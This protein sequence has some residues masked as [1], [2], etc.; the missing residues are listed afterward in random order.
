MLTLLFLSTRNLRIANFVLDAFGKKIENVDRFDEIMSSLKSKNNWSF[1]ETL[2]LN[3]IFPIILK[4]YTMN[5]TLLHFSCVL[6][7]Q[8]LICTSQKIIE[9]IY[10]LF[11]R[12]NEDVICFKKKLLEYSYFAFYYRVPIYLNEK[13]NQTTL[14]IENCQFIQE[15]SKKE[16]LEC[17][18]VFYFKILVEKRKEKIFLKHLFFNFNYLLTFS[19]LSL[20]NSM[21]IFQNPM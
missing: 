19:W 5:T 1:N 9:I 11:V 20:A 7:Y 17:W 10:K 13:S 16:I 6:F 4:S 15:K 3:L 18:S 14:I 21:H 8:S 2:N 12:K